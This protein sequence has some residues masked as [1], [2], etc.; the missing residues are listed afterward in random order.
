MQ[1]EYLPMIRAGAPSAAAG[2]PKRLKRPSMRWRSLR[3]TS[4][5]DEDATLCPVYLGGEA[6]LASQQGAAAAC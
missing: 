3:P 5:E 4:W 2:P 6:Y 1:S